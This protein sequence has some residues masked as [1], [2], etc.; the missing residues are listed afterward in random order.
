[1]AAANRLHISR[2]G[3]KM[4]QG[5]AENQEIIEKGDGGNSG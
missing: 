5:S 1:M 2:P 3:V 4:T